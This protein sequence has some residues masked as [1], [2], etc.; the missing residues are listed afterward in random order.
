MFINMLSSMDFDRNIWYI[1]PACAVT[2]IREQFSNPE[3]EPY[4]GYICIKTNEAQSLP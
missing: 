1:S 4:K 3:G 2:K